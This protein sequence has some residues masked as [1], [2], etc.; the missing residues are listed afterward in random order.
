M[1]RIEWDD[2]ARKELRL[3]GHTEQQRIIRYLRERI[4]TTED[5]RR[6]GKALTGD[7][8]GLWRYR[9]GDHRIVCRIEED[10][11]IVLI[12]AVGHRKKIYD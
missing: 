8:A 3:L 12:L 9:I 11:F 4:T 7:K 1:W 5:P 10:R 2:A 6:F